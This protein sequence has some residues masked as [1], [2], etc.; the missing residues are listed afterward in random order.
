MIIDMIWAVLRPVLV[1]LVG[2]IPSW[3]LP[4]VSGMFVA[5]APVFQF[6][7]WMNHYLPITLAVTLLAVRYSIVGAIYAFRVVEWG[8]TKLHILGGSS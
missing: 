7:G 8:L 5:A 4:N 6:I 3:E 2:L 1:S